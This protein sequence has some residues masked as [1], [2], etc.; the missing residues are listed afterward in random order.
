M[1]SPERDKSPPPSRS[2]EASPVRKRSASPVRKRSAS[3]KRSP[4]RSPVRRSSRS[5]RREEPKRS[6]SPDRRARDERRRSRSRSRDRRRSRSRS[7]D[8]RRSRSR[9]RDR[10]R[11]GRS[12]SPAVRYGLPPAGRTP[13]RV[14]TQLF[15]AGIH[16]HVNERDLEERFSRY[17]RVK[18]A[19]VV[20]HPASGESRGFAFVG[21]SAE[22]EAEDAARDMNGR[23][24]NGR[25]LLV[26]IARNPR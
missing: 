16:F 18:E 11:G 2:R 7:R 14:G 19:R 3:P 12:R 9:S 5:P 13:P 26:E 22:E 21:M 8:R 23:D 20:R 15:V 1:G 6:R 10:P 17:G 4:A 25:R 24:W